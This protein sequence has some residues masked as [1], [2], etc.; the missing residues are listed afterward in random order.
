MALFT[1][2]VENYPRPEYYDENAVAEMP[3]PQT[4]VSSQI[5]SLAKEIMMLKDA[6]SRLA[7]RLGRVL[8]SDDSAKGVGEKAQIMLCPLASDIRDAADEIALLRISLN[9]MSDR[10]EI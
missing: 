10:L 8:R 4:Q 5:D 3:I 6:R 1:N 7:E 9:N 2:R